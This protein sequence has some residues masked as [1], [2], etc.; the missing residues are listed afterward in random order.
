MMILWPPFTGRAAPGEE[1]ELKVLDLVLD[2][3]E[4]QYIKDKQAMAHQR[5]VSGV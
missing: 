1:P 3:V 2:A 4:Q 5:E